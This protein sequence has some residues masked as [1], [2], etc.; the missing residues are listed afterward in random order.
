MRGL[1]FE[2]EIISAEQG[3]E[4]LTVLEVI[5]REAAKNGNT[6]AAMPY[7]FR[8]AQL[9]EPDDEG[10]APPGSVEQWREQAYLLSRPK[11]N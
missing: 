9:N 3:A 8:L 7:L 2:H 4:D 11:T 6:D 10:I 1:G 5:A